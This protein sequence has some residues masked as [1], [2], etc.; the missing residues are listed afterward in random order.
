MPVKYVN[1]NIFD[2][3]CDIICHQTNCQGVMGHG[4]ALQV[5][6]RYPNV[7]ERYKMCCEQTEDKEDLLGTVLYLETFDK[8]DRCIANIFGQLNYGEGL[9]T[10]Y[11]KLAKGFDD[12][13]EFAKEWNYSVAIPYKIGCGLAHG[14]WEVVKELIESIFADVDCTVYRFEKNEKYEG[15]VK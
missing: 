10:N 13:A 11:G 2:T 4:I 8:K 15:E 6:E 12:I 14:N 7:Y 1:G 3:D 9:Q 5:K